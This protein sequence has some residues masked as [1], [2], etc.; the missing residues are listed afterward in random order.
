MAKF[1]DVLIAWQVEA[2]PE[3]D[4]AYAIDQRLREMARG[5]LTDAFASL[6]RAAARARIGS[7]L[8]R[9]LD[10]VRVVRR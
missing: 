3:L 10:M 8:D 7:D 1:S 6:A 4:P 2:Q 5:N 9:A